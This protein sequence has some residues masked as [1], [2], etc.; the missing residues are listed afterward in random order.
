M[1]KITRLVMVLGIMLLVLLPVFAG[2]AEEAKEAEAPAE[3]VVEEGGP[4][5]S[6]PLSDVRVRKAIAYAIDMDTIADTLLEGM[7]I[8][9]DSQIPNGSWKAPGLEPY[10]YDPDRARALLKAANWDESI[11]LDLVYY[12]ADQLTADLM[13]AVQAYLAD[14]GVQMTFRKLEGDVAGQLNALPVDPVDGPSGIV[15][16]LGYGARAALAL[17]EYYNGYTAG[18]TATTPSD[19]KLDEL[20]AGISSTSDVAKQKEAFFAIERYDSEMLYTLPLYYQQLFV[21]ESTKI[22]RNGEMYGNAQ[23]N[24]DW[25]IINWTVP[26]DKNGNHVLNTNTGPIEFFQTPWFNPGIFM[27][28]KVLF[29]RLITT[30][31]S[32]TPTRGIMV[33][34]YSLSADGKTVTFELKE[35]LTWHDGSPLTVDDVRFS[36]EFA[37]TVIPAVHPVFMTTFGSLK[38]FAAF[39]DGSADEI[40]GI[41]IN[42]NTITFKFDKLDPNVLLTFSQFAILPEKYL[43]D[44]DPLQFQQ[45]PYWQ[46]PIGSGPFK[47]SEVEMNDYLIMV[48]FE[49]YQ[50][51]VAKI[52]QIVC[53]PTFEND[54]NMVKNAASGRLDYAF[55][56][57]TSDVAAIL[58][59]DNM[60]VTPVD[61]PYTREI[62]FNKFP[63]P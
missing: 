40:S 26:A 16:D 18:I 15:W 10:S 24:Y 22:N 5:N 7:A 12:Y 28:N 50:E 37:S 21:F 14:V 42:G 35:G 62:W 29:D 54:V 6:N 58:E 45:D 34:D 4:T 59:M 49:N 9:A 8:V 33:D 61:I 43:G 53:Y 2:G 17:Q 48:P 39:K 57:S 52:D 55:G 46:W 30:D 38:G 23:Y 27:T 47:V 3:M 56:K 25:G 31:G 1:K 32:L 11:V 60:K 51:G 19:P 44:A 36:V 41:T 13:T 63:K 20:I